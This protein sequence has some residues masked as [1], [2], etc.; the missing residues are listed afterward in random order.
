MRERPHDVSTRINETE[1]H[2]L[3][4]AA[5]LADKPVSTFLREHVLSA[6]QEQIAAPRDYEEAA[7]R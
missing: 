6:A 5:R 3:V 7:A 4:A 1:R 2:I